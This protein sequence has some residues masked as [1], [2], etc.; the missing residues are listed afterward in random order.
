[1]FVDRAEITVRGGDGGNGCCSFRR[2][3]FVPRGGPDGGN[4]GDGGNVILRAEI[5]EQSLV[6]LSYNR[7]YAAQRGPNGKGKDMHGRKAPDITLK[8][9]VG[10][11]V[12]NAETGEMLADMETPGMEF[13]AAH[14]GKGGRGN[15]CFATS[16]N[17]APRQW[18]EGTEGEVFRLILELKTI[19]DVG[20][21]GYPN[22]GKSTLLRALSAARPKV[23]PY[24]FT[25]L[26]PTVGVVEYPDFGRLTVADIPG[27]IDGAHRNVGLGHAFLRHIERTHILLYVLDMAGTDGRTPWE[28]FRHLQNELELYMKGLSKRPAVIAANKMDVPESAENLA[29]LREELASEVIDV[30]P[31]AA[32]TG[33]LGE[34]RELLRRKVGEARAASPFFVGERYT[35]EVDLVASDTE[36]FDLDE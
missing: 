3:K 20:L 31:I 5:N 14:G 9:P 1:M 22:A 8:V 13:I 16:S 24:P 11:V 32:E 34:L 23:A 19:A 2:E 33:E 27:L 17:R 29:L 18:E 30:V 6:D 25:T 4:G 21:V 26:H 28:D 35:G 36:V 10:T 12:V 15:A 7:H